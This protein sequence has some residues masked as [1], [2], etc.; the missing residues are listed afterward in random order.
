MSDPI[1]SVIIPVHNGGHYLAA[2]IDSALEQTRLP[3]E[4]IVVDDGSAD[5]SAAI[6]RSFGPPVRVLTQANLGRP[7]RAAWAWP[8]TG[9]L[10]GF[11]D[12][13]DLWLPDKLTRQVALY[14]MT[15]RLRQSWVGWRIS[16]VQNWMQCSDTLW[17]DQPGQSGASYW[18][19]TGL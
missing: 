12:A 8:A 11:L 16:L 13:D 10:L 9:D 4:V 18:R 14:K 1:I 5:G 17:G 19:V 3:D 2:A 6:A 7:Q 15:L